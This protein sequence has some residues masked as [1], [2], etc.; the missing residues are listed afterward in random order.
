MELS[1]IV[2]EKCRPWVWM[3]IKLR[4][5]IDLLFEFLQKKLRMQRMSDHELWINYSN[6]R[7]GW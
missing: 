1:R 2:V 7:P 5:A 6:V 3:V 4:L